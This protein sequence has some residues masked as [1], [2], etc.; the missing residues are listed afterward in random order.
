[1]SRC[2]PLSL[3]L[4]LKDENPRKG[5]RRG[6]TFPLRRRRRCSNFSNGNPMLMLMLMSSF[7]NFRKFQAR[8][9]RKAASSLITS[10]PECVCVTVC[11]CVW[12]W[13][14]KCAF[15]VKHV[16]KTEQPQPKTQSAPHLHRW[17][18]QVLAT[19]L[20][21]ALTRHRRLI[22]TALFSSLP[23]SFLIFLSYSSA[24]C[25]WKW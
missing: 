21:L 13:R 23:L 25:K 4:S 18:Q 7:L 8:N 14:L 3:S 12:M 6:A 11:V 24:I 20:P 2:L 22:N 16:R 15:W 5:H 1:M 19:L 10:V 17:Y 9:E